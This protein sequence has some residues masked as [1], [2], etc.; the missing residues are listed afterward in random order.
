M[1]TFGNRRKDSQAHRR[2]RRRL[3]RLRLCVCDPVRPC[4]KGADQPL[5]DLKK[6]FADAVAEEG[7]VGAGMY[8]VGPNGVVD[9]AF[10]GFADRERVERPTA[11][12]SGTGR[13]SPRRSPAIA[14][15]QLRDRGRL[16][17]DDPI[18]KYVPELARGAQPVRADVGGH[19]PPAAVARVGLPIRDLA[20]GRG[21]A[22]ASVRA[23]RVGAAR[24]DAALHRDPIRAG[25][26]NISYSNPGIRLPGPDH[27]AAG[28]RG[29]RGVHAEE[30]A[31]AARHD[32]QLLRRH[33]VSPDRGP[34]ATT[35]T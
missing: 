1:R 27:R 17:L 7:I 34:L 16:S 23:D 30:R 32:A 25:H 24:G 8:L 21:Q 18:V 35:I 19:D 28:G 15:M 12:R 2:R 31:L 4:R 22:L 29:F 10:A 26:R 20:V 6:F 13:R 5:G 33:A 9:S 11:P 3:L 14:I